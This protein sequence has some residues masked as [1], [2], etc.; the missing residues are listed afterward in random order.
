MTRLFQI[1][2]LQLFHLIVFDVHLLQVHTVAT[3]AAQ[4][5]IPYCIHIFSSLNIH[6][7]LKI[8]VVAI[9]EI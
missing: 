7:I 8:T 2:F 9:N 3:M 4:L 5:Q 1:L 6:L